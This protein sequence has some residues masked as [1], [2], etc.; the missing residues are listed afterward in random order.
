MS[1][2]PPRLRAALGWSTRP[3]PRRPR[4]VPHAQDR[5]RR[6]RRFERVAALLLGGAPRELR[7]GAAEGRQRGSEGRNA[8]NEFTVGSSLQGRQAGG[9]VGV[10]RRRGPLRDG[11][12]LAGV[13]GDTALGDDVA[14]DLEADRG[15]AELALR[16]VVRIAN[17]A[18]REAPKSGDSGRIAR[19]SIKSR[20][21]KLFYS[22][23]SS[24]VGTHNVK[25]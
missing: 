20:I 9:H 14:G 15:A 8:W 11:G 5:R 6:Q 4:R 19:R 1:A 13:G 22:H 25:I 23:P 2:H 12:D 7:T 18:N 17:R 3:A 24:A 16:R 10:R 21:A